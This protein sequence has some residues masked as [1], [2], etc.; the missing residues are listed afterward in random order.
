MDCSHQTPVAPYT[1]LNLTC[2]LCW[3][4]YPTCLKQLLTYYKQLTLEFWG[5]DQIG[6]AQFSKHA[7]SLFLTSSQIVGQNPWINTY[8]T[9]DMSFSN[10]DEKPGVVPELV[11]TGRI[12][13]STD[14]QG[15]FFFLIT[16]RA[17]SSATVC[18]GVMPAYHCRTLGIKVTKLPFLC[19]LIKVI[20][21][22]MCSH[23]R[24]PWLFATPWTIVIFLE[25]KNICCLMNEG[26][27]N[28]MENIFTE[29]VFCIDRATYF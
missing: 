14:L 11:L 8:C 4:S 7:L 17:I 24:S 23:F 18:F 28:W 15:F 16:N 2:S 6:F 13:I 25:L 12:S 10:Q 21:V 22:H 26:Q 1:L 27:K 9:S 19:P 29:I 3:D 20:Y 5:F